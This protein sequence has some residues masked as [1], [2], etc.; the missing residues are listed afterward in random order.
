MQKQKK[1]NY[2]VKFKQ[3]MQMEK[4][5]INFAMKIKKNGQK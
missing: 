5:L 3:N 2:G 1:I 4:I